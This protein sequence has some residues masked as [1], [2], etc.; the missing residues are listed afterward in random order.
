MHTRGLV[1]VATAALLITA[2][3]SSVPETEANEPAPD[4]S[5]PTMRLSESQDIRVTRDADRGPQA[6][7]PQQVGE[8][9]I[10]FFNA[11]NRSEVEEALKYLAPELGWY[12][13]TEGN[14]RDGGRHFVAYDANKL[15]NYMQR[16]VR[17]DERMHLLEIDVDYERAR[18]IGHV[19]YNLLRTAKDLTDYA[20]EVGGKGAIDCASGRIAVWSMAQGPKRLLVGGLCPGQADPPAL[21]VA[22]AR[23]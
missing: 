9:V 21:A 19:A 14:P 11:V 10:A 22:C 13:V 2:A 20:P 7:R 17:V 18:D 4:P 8:T 12:S 5:N 15:R 6:C 16:R 23:K 3:C 1:S